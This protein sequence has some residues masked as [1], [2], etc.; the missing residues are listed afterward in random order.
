ML[1]VDFPGPVIAPNSDLVFEVE[2][3]QV[4][5]GPKPPNVFKMIDIDNDDHLTKDEVRNP[6]VDQILGRG[7][8][9]WN[10]AM[11][12][13]TNITKRIYIKLVILAGCLFLL[14]LVVNTN[15]VAKFEVASSRL[16]TYCK[17]L[18]KPK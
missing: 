5:D 16:R 14:I 8:A 6:P 4:H 11:R 1:H 7:G 17:I 10:K 15:S 9:H 3:I 2:L 12:Y 18:K 13:I